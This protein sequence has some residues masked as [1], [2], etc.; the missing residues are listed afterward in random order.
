MS[1]KNQEEILTELESLTKNLYLIYNEETGEEF[2][3]C[4]ERT[5]AEKWANYYL[6]SGIVVRLSL[7]AKDWGGLN[8]EI[9][10]GTTK[11][12][13][14]RITHVTPDRNSVKSKE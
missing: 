11:D 6:N 9:V 2:A 13:V 14:E 3:L 7:L 10:T 5:E 12:C 4:A 8:E 1:E